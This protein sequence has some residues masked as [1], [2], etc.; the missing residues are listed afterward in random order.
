[1][2]NLNE[3]IWLKRTDS[4]NDELKRRIC[5]LDNLSVVAALSQDNGRGQQGNSWSSED[6]KNLLFSIAL[7][8]AE[9]SEGILEVYDHFAIGEMAALAVSDFLAQH[10]IQTAVKWPNDIYAGDRKICGILI[11]NSIRG[12]MITRSIIG[13]GLNI[14]QRNFPIT[15]PNPTS[16]ALET[17]KEYDLKDSLHEFMDIFRKY[18]DR[19]LN[20]CGGLL[21]LHEMYCSQMWRKDELSSFIDNTS[22]NT[23][24]GCIEGVSEN[25]KIIIRKSDG[26]IYE[27]AFREITYII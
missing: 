9:D 23:F 1:M 21:K 7:K 22:G 11:E 16:M 17:Q 19:Y 20:I 3:I 8:T 15:I 13:I 2:K 24:Q 5:Q 12:N 18:H 4:T 10:G 27:F 14:N 26:E 6:G 25:G